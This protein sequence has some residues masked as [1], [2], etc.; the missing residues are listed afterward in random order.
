MDVTRERIGRILELR[1][2]LLSFQTCCDLVSAAVVDYTS[3]CSLRRMHL[4]QDQSVGPENR[5]LF[6]REIF[7]LFH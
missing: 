2:M 6:L 5:L 7:F 3:T 1:E 4:D